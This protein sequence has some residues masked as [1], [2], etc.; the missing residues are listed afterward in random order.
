[1][2]LTDH[3]TLE[4]LI[5]SN[6]AKARGLDNIP[7]DEQAAYLLKLAVT[8]LEPARAL[9]GTPMKINSGFRS[10]ALNAAVGG[11]GKSQHMLGQAA[12]FVTPEMDLNLAYD[13]IKNSDIPFDQLI[14][15]TKGLGS[16]WIHISCAGE[17]P[18]RRQILSLYQRNRKLLG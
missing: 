10:P 4:E 18:P 7:S 5:Q 17:D 6:T 16:N 14:Y 1:M 9:L 11:V 3:F 2:K 8:V 12:D 13:A 15:E